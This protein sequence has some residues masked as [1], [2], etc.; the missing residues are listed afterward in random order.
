MSAANSSETLLDCIEQASIET[1]LE[2]LDLVGEV[3]RERLR[4]DVRLL[5]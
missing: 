1:Q 5:R 3:A 4:R 2:F